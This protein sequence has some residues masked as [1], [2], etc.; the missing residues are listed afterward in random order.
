MTLSN[1][2]KT[3]RFETRDLEFDGLKS[4][5]LNSVPSPAGTEHFFPTATREG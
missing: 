5:L 3:H 2:E 4:V 1:K